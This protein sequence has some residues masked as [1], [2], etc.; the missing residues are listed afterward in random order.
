[1]RV[2][3]IV[4]LLLFVPLPRLPLAHQRGAASPEDLDG[5]VERTMTAFQVPG[6]SLA[7]VKDGK[8]VAAKGL[9]G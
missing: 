8:V 2:L 3:L 9:L 4:A 5:W 6:L 1:M 7:L